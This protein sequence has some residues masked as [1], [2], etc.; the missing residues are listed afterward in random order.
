MTF[1]PSLVAK[2]LAARMSDIEVAVDRYGSFSFHPG[3]SPPPPALPDGQAEPAARDLVMRAL[4]AFAD[5]LNHQILRHLADGDTPLPE[6]ADLVGLPRLSVWERVNDL[7][8]VGLVGHGHEDDR[9]GLSASGEALM[10]LV[11]E[12]VAGIVAENAR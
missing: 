8:Q 7:V 6:L 3:G 9:A 11:N 5:P 4:G 12:I 10:H 2:S 1:D